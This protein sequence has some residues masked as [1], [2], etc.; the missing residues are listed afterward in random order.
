MSMKK[1]RRERPFCGL[2]GCFHGLV[3]RPRRNEATFV[4]VVQLGLD[5]GAS[6]QRSHR[7]VGAWR[8]PREV[9]SAAAL[10]LAPRMHL[11]CAC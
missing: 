9:V 10:P 1:P 4:L 3:G 2:G 6:H 5:L 11:K 7:P 8:V